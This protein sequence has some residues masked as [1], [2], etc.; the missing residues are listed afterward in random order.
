MSL[1]RYQANDKSTADENTI[2][3]EQIERVESVLEQLGTVHDRAFAMR[4]KEILDGLASEETFEQAHKLLGELLGFDAGKVE[5]DGSPDPW[6]IAGNLCLVFEDHAGAQAGSSLHVIKA[7][8]VASHPAWMRASVE[9][10]SEANILPVLVTPVTKADTGA[11]PHLDDVA[12]WPLEEFRSW[13]ENALATV[14]EVRKTFP[15]PGDLAWRAAAAEV[16][17][18]NGLDASGLFATLRS[19]PAAKHLTLTN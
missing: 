15:E 1:A 10:T 13:A 17:E 4:E 8:Q 7:R 12:L 2:L 3:M 11:I 14:R 18:Q 6:W 5:V 9:A 19:R 16:F